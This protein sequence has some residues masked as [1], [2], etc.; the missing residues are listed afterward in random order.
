MIELI[1][2]GVC[3]SLNAILSL[4]EMAFVTVSRPELRQLSKKNNL[5]AV[6]LSKL[7]ENP[8]RTLSVLQI[9][10]TVVGSVSAAVGGAGAKESIVP[11]LMEHLSLSETQADAFSILLVV[12]PLTYFS[13]VLGELVPKTIALRFPLR[14]ALSSSRWLV[15]GENLLNPFVKAL[16]TSTQFFIRILFPKWKKTVSSPDEADSVSLSNLSGQHREFVINLVHIENQRIQDILV[17][18]SEVDYVTTSTSLNEVLSMIIKS[19]HTRLPVLENDKLI[20]LLHSKEFITF[21]STGDENWRHIIR[22]LLQVR[23]QAGLLKTL[24]L[25]QEKRSHM[26]IVTDFEDL[27]GVV[28]LEDIMEE[29]VGDISDEDD[30]GRLRKLMSTRVLQK[31]KQKT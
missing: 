25:M 18:W 7:R 28:T 4:V 15:F 23:P 11:Y 22:P 8:E 20:G 29:I 9:G 26:A 24:R 31:S 17:P 10:I 13:V 16:E 6:R 19:G 30:D 5:A 1:I 12:I 3:L 2:V 14:I 27:I 21:V